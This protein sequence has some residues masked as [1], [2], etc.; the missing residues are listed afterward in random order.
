MAFLLTPALLHT[1]LTALTTLALSAAL[2][3]R[4][5][6][7]RFHTLL[8]ALAAPCLLVA[9]A[10]PALCHAPF[11]MLHGTWLPWFLSAIR[12][13]LLT[14]LISMFMLS[15]VTRLTPGLLTTIRYF[16]LSPITA[17]RTVWLPLPGP[18]FLAA[19]LAAFLLSAG[20]AVMPVL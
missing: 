15:G 8:A 20:M 19:I 17:L 18:F 13:L 16:S 3:C 11:P 9:A 7:L 12:G 5:G 1:V 2:S 4:P 14:P 10:L 6:A